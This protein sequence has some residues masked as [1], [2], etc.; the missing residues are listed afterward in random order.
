MAQTPHNEPQRDWLVYETLPKGF[1][2]RKL[3]RL[4]I[5]RTL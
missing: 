2:R 1:L 5:Q 3:V 4:H